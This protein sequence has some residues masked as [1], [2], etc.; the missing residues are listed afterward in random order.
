MIANDVNEKGI[1]NSTKEKGGFRQNRNF[2]GAA[3]SM[4]SWG[5][6]DHRPT[7]VVNT[8]Q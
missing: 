2:A 1:E 8:H 7:A 5:I 3:S 4:C 6:T